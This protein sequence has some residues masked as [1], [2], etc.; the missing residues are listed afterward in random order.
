MHAKKIAVTAWLL[1]SA[2]ALGGCGASPPPKELVDARAA[3]QR[4]KT[5]RANRVNP[6]EVH[7]ARQALDSA[8]HAFADDG[9]SLDTR[10]KAYIALR[11]AQFA[12][13]QAGAKLAAQDRDKAINDLQ[14]LQLASGKKT[15]A[16]LARTRAELSKTRDAV[17]RERE[18]RLEAEKRAKEALENLAK[19]AAIKEEPRGMVITLSGS[20]LFGS[21]KWTLLP[22]AMQKLNEVAVALQSAKDRNVLVEGHTDSQGSDA[23]NLDLSQKR[24]DA[25][26]DY[27][28]TRGVPKDMISAKGIGEARP[29]AENTTAEGR[30]NNRRVE[31]IVS[32]PE[33]K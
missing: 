28:V 21:G 25:V 14:E 13:A 23:Y 20:V 4:A 15:A 24:A 32:P 33:K 30:A 7:V 5:G 26:R 1:L 3:F 27:L 29:V 31:I 17:A 12:D 22:A 8:E 6:A 19:I 11:K 16:E 2:L 9:P 18:A 10:D